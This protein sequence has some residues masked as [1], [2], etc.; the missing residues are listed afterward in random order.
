MSKNQGISIAGI[1]KFIG[2]LITLAITWFLFWEVIQ[3]V[4]ASLSPIFMYDGDILT[5][6]SADTPTQAA[7]IAFVLFGIFVYIL[8]IILASDFVYEGADE[9]IETLKG[10]YVLVILL[11]LGI[12]ATI[13]LFPFKI[14]ARNILPKFGI[15]RWD[16]DST[17]DNS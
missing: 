11:P 6:R 12:I 1:G 4:L 7:L 15:D 3:P 13:I 14:I 5:G 2:M 8:M 16:S 17:E 10:I 9:T